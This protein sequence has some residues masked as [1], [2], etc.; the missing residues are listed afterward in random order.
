[1]EGNIL[2]KN[3]IYD[4]VNDNMKWKQ[5]EMTCIINTMKW[6]KSMKKVTSDM[7]AERRQW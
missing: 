5:S 7:K 3:N 1:M 2:K 4:M 6:W